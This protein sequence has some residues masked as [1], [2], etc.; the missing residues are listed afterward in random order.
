MYCKFQF[1]KLMKSVTFLCPNKKVTKEVVRGEALRA[2]RI[3]AP[4]PTPAAFDH[5]PLKMSR[6]F[7][8]LYGADLQIYMM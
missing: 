5:R 8:G 7:S 4:D 6:F 2:N 3:L 1:I